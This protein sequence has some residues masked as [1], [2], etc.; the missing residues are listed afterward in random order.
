MR[1]AR[2]HEH[3]AA[4]EVALLADRCICALRPAVKELFKHRYELDRFRQTPCPARAAGELSARGLDD[5][6]AMRA[7]TFEIFLRHG[8]FVHRRIHGRR[9]ENR[10][11]CGQ[12]G[13]R[14][15]VVCH[16]AGRFRKK[17]RSCRCDEHDVGKLCE[18][19]VLD[20]VVRD[21]R[22]HV[23]DDGFV[24][25]LAE[26]KFRHEVLRTARHDDVDMRAFLPETAHD[27]DGLVRRDAARH[28][29]DDMLSRQARCCFRCFHLRAPS[30][31]HCSFLMT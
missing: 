7:Q 19:D 5:M 2:R 30:A 1:A 12:H 22:P 6:E 8:V 23:R 9:D 29:E 15:H 28:A 14:Q 21:F 31:A 16:A 24:A 25:H 4:D 11:L 13:R 20:M 10:R 26:R 18:R 27:F 3:F 17:V